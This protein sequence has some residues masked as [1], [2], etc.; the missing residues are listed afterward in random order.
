MPSIWLFA[1]Y[2]SSTWAAILGAIFLV[3]RT[4][5]FLA[6]RKEPAKR[7]PGFGLS[8]LPTLVLLLGGLIGAVLSFLGSG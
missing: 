2:V 1:T 6:Y 4:M 8:I 5:Y 7:G 3:G